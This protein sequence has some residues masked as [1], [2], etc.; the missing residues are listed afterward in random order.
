MVPD[1][2]AS[3]VAVLCVSTGSGT[4][5]AATADNGCAPTTVRTGL[6]SRRPGLATVTVSCAAGH[7]AVSRQRQLGRI[8]AN[9]DAAT[10]RAA[11]TLPACAAVP[12]AIPAC[13]TVPALPG[14]TAVP[15]GTEA[16]G[17][18][19]RFPG[20]EC[21]NWTEY[22]HLADARPAAGLV[23]ACIQWLYRTEFRTAR[24]NLE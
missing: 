15:A 14:A 8:R 9:T 5:Y 16:V 4:G 6:C 12:A 2:Q 10:C 3:A 22:G 1:A 23:S 24:Y 11:A 20:R 18:A 21:W 13:A 19:G 17:C 7:A